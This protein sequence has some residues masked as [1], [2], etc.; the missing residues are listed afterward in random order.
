[1]GLVLHGVDF[2]GADS[3][4]SQKIVVAT[5][6]GAEE[7]VL[8]RRIS[9][10]ELRT[11]ILESMGQPS[12]QLWRIDAPF[13]LSSSIYQ[14]HG[15]EP[16]W[17]ALA[18]WMS[19][20]ATARDWRRAMRAVDRKEPKR[21]CDRVARTPMAPMNLRVFKQTWTVI[22][23]VLLPLADAGVHV[24]P[25]HRTESSVLVTEGCPASVLFARGESSRGYKGSSDGHR[26]RR[27]RLCGL[28]RDWG[29][30]L[31][32]QDRRSAVEDSEGDVLDA[33]LLLA[34]STLHV[35]PAEAALEGWI[36]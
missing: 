27:S 19:G 7:V 16:S 6:N 36:W 17:R 20:F 14:R 28:M 2:P 15:I 25:L 24:A 10:I 11:M 21:T 34:D 5:R 3:G 13:S 1:M 8:R 22:R 9:R 4:G 35:P 32:P 23:D 33:A 26:Q 29:I 31:S 12:A 30:D 18:E